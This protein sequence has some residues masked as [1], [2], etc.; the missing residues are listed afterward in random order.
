[1]IHLFVTS[2]SKMLVSTRHILTMHVHNPGECR[3]APGQLIDATD[4]STNRTCRL[5]HQDTREDAWI[6][7]F[8]DLIYEH[9]QG[10]TEA[11][12]KHHDD[13]YGAK[14]R[15]P[16]NYTKMLWPGRKGCLASHPGAIKAGMLE[17]LG[18]V[19]RQSQF[20]TMCQISLGCVAIMF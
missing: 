20:E 14:V 11:E 12:K 6:A 1:M 10:M 4:A 2:P 13:V 15:R 8:V 17:K 3:R 18:T 16:R 19:H 9:Y 5:E 7:H